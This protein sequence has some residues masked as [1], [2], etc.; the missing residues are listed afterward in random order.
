MLDE[1]GDYNIYVNSNLTA[2]M[3]VKACQHEFSH[4]DNGDYDHIGLIQEIEMLRHY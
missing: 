1:N 2:E 3:Q 4:I